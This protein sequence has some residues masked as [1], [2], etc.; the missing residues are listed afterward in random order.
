MLCATRYAA[1]DASLVLPST[2][3]VPMLP[4]T[5]AS[6]TS[7]ASKWQH[8]PS[9]YCPI[10]QQCMHDPVVL[11][12][13]HTYERRYIERWLEH[14]STSPVSGL[15]LPQK[16]MFPNHAL[17]NAIREYFDEV[18]CVH[19][20]AI[21]QSVSGPHASHDLG[22]NTPLLRTIDALMQCSLLMNADLSIEDVLRQIMDEAKTLVGA[23]VASVFL[24][25]QAHQELYSTV[26][27]TGVPIRIPVGYG[28]AGHVATTGEPEIINDTYSDMRFN[29]SV[30]VKTGFQT[31]NMMCVP[32]KVKKGGVIGVVQ[33]INKSGPST[34]SS[35]VQTDSFGMADEEFSADDLQFLQVF[36]CQAATA[37][38]NSGIDEQTSFPPSDAQE[39]DNGSF[40]ESFKCFLSEGPASD[41]SSFFSLPP[42]PL[43]SPPSV[44]EAAAAK[45]PSSDGSSFLSLPPT[46]LLSLSSAAEAAAGKEAF[47]WGT[48]PG[49]GGDLEPPSRDSSKQ[50]TFGGGAFSEG[51]GGVSAAEGE[52][53]GKRR[54]GRARQR[55]AKYWSSVRR[56]TP[57]P[58]L[59]EPPRAAF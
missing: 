34:F 59:G 3:G 20:R 22:V 54:S 46:P 26:N 4:D 18:F 45:D 58:A 51:G 43:L 24:L 15:Q 37:I 2:K 21:R 39:Q 10:S 47:H 44:S 14:H 52:G 23:E 50:S 27:S 48:T 19:R 38:A 7:P 55:A 6:D 41:G 30:D 5:S 32:L 17:R 8:P 28:I 13:G 12:D 56:R 9:F 25:D 35:P 29:K 49:A 16:D 40:C 1:S 33:L 36:A 42:T 53:R 11:A 57:S 31:R